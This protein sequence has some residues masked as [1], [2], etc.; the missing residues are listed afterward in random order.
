ME[1]TGVVDVPVKLSPGMAAVLSGMDGVDIEIVVWRG[2]CQ[3]FP[4]V[5]AILR[6]EGGFVVEPGFDA[7]YETSTL[8]G[9]C[10]F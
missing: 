8:F 2:N 7:K 3:L 9:E 4:L 6:S 1:R 10:F 5:Y